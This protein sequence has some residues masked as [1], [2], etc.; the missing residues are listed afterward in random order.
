MEKPFGIDTSS[1]QGG[2]IDWQEMKARGVLFAGMRASVGVRVDAWFKRNWQKAKEAGIFRTAYC[3]I[4][5]NIDPVLQANLFISL[6]KDDPGELPPTL[7]LEI[8]AGKSVAE[9]IKCIETVIKLVT[10]Q[11]GK[12]VLY[13]RANWVDTYM[14]GCK[15]LNNY[16]WWLA[17][18]LRTADEHPGPP[19]LPKTVER[20][21]VIIHQTSQKGTPM[22]NIATKQLD[23]DRWQFDINHLYAYA[24]KKM[25]FMDYLAK[26]AS[27][28][29]GKVSGLA[30]A[31]AQL[32][33]IFEICKSALSA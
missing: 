31:Q 6:I 24:G 16:D 20:S 2:L 5:P 12:P 1:Y 28:L 10:D 3:A 30:D 8:D 25:S 15:W 33:Q 18:Y 26:I 22:G 29:T 17:Q 4:W 14:A 11:I 21:R 27:L 7:D 13:S 32:Q 19:T 9:I 23:L